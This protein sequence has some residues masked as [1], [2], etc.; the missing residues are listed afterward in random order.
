MQEFTPQAHHMELTPEN[1]QAELNAAALHDAIECIAEIGPERA[2]ELAVATLQSYLLL[3]MSRS[4]PFLEPTA[5]TEP[6]IEALSTV[7]Q[8]CGL[9]INTTVHGKII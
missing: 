3:T 7:L 9:R 4:L 2:I 5:K 1:Y 6:A 8:T